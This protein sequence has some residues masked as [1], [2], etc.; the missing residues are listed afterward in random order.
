MGYQIRGVKRNYYT[1][2]KMNKLIDILKYKFV[3][4]ALYNRHIYTHDL[5]SNTKQK[6]LDCGL[7]VYIDNIYD[8]TLLTRIHY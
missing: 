3:V 8:P 4:H 5:D 2:Q 6:L 7:A 1:R